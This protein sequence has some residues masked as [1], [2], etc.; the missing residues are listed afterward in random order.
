MYFWTLLISVIIVFIS[1]LILLMIAFYRNPLE[2]FQTFQRGILFIKGY[3][4]NWFYT[5]ADKMVYYKAGK[6]EKVI[7]IHGFMVN[8]TNWTAI[9]PKLK[10]KYEVI[11][12]ELPGHGGSPWT[13]SK[14]LEELGDVI[15]AFLLEISENEQVTLVGSSMGGAVAFQ[16]ALDYP[17]R[18]KN[19]IVINSAGLEWK[20]D[21]KILLPQN[22]E[23]A[24]YK[25]HGIIN[26]KLNLPNFF[27]DAILKQVTPDFENLL[28]SAI[29]TP[30]H[31]MDNQ[32]QN[33]KIKPHVLWGEKDGLFPMPYAEKLLTLLPDYEFKTFPKDAH[34]PHNTNPEEMLSYI[35]GVVG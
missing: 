9:A 18:V 5:G 29:S 30:E 20:I 26:P 10:K 17:E 8:A 4:K 16:F 11:I 25:I 28:K 3:R 34:V 12:P 31:F 23:E 1:P 6:G 32:F 33:L 15:L 35:Y 24:Q 27:L 14:N 13:K 21:K 22:R 7:L 2:V 19:L